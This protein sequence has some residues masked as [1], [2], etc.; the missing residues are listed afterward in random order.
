[1]PMEV[2][3]SGTPNGWKVSIM[4]EELKAAGADVDWTVTDVNVR[5]SLPPPSRY[6]WAITPQWRAPSSGRATSSRRSSRR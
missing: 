6:P 4:L 1:M 5:P 3:F 2:F